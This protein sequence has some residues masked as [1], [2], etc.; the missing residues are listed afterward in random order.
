MKQNYST[1]LSGLSRWKS[2]K[3]VNIL[4]YLGIIFDETISWAP[5]IQYILS[6]A[7]KRLGLLSW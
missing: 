1:H 3:R 2:L 4:T 6:K 7:G 5:H